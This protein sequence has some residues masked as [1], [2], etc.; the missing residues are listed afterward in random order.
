MALPAKILEKLP[1]GVRWARPEDGEGSADQRSGPRPLSFGFTPLDALLPDGGLPRGA[2]VELAVRG[3]GLASS[4][5]LAACR[6]AQQEGVHQGAQVP[7]CAFIDPAGSLYAPAI[8]RAGVESSRLLVVRPLVEALARVTVRVVESR[9]FAVVVIDTVGVPGA[10]L[11]ISLA[12]WPRVVRRLATATVATAATVL[13]IT[14]AAAPRPLPL[15]V[16]MRVE[17]A[18]PSPHQLSVQV[19]KEKHGRVGNPRVLAWARPLFTPELGPAQVGKGSAGLRSTRPPPPGG[20]DGE[21]R[22]A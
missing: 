19:V 16:A 11:E 22:L 10:P 17:L 12:A 21:R 18:R 14:D 15:P 6:A 3:G 8:Q 7:W 1:S 9:A 20:S 4:L 2:V 13:L 5:A